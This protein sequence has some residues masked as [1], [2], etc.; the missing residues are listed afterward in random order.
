MKKSL[1]LLLAVLMI[2]PLLASCSSKDKDQQSATTQAPTNYVE[3]KYNIPDNL[4]EVTF[5][6]TTFRIIGEGNPNGWNADDILMPESDSADTLESARYMRYVSVQD[7]F[8]VTFETITND[9]IYNAVAGSVK[10]GDKESFDLIFMSTSNTT[11]AAIDGYLLNLNTVPYL[12]LEQPYYDQNYIEDMS[13]GDTLYSAVTDMLTIDTHCMWIMMYNRTM[14]DKLGLESPYDLVQKN[15]WTLDKLASMLDLVSVENG[16]GVWDEKDQ[17]GLVTHTG[18][19]RNF[20]YSSDMKICEKDPET[21]TPVLAIE[22]NQR[23]LTVMEKAK[24]VLYDGNRTLLSN[25]TVQY[26]ITGNFMEGKSLFLAEIAGYLGAFREMEDDYGV[27]P[28][29]KLNSSQESYYT[30][31]DPCIMV[32]SIPDFKRDVNDSDLERIGIIT[33]ALC[34]ASYRHLRPAYYEDVLG[35]KNTRHQEDYDMLNLCKDSRVYDFGLFND[36]GSLSHI[37]ETLLKDKNS[38]Y[39]SAVKAP[40]R[41][42]KTKLN[43]LIEQYEKDVE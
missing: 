25:S 4:P 22:D 18:A 34:A 13:I 29:P 32:M 5:P 6:D 35:G 30:S 21:N 28:Y 41:Q 37:F 10:A 40:L 24:A 7:R 26:N 1:S 8:G 20:F 36:L 9:N 27:V 11:K 3:D 15:E 42:A 31:N 16:D 12:D 19:A 43:K 39:A 23:M 2:L 14:I 33:E 38:N 17:Y